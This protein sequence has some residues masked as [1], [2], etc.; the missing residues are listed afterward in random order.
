MTL[1]PVYVKEA[2]N[3]IDEDEIEVH[4]NDGKSPAV[5]NPVG[6]GNYTYVVMPLRV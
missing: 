2:L 4:L 3:A 6:G 5:I 1:N